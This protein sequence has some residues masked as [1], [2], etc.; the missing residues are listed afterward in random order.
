MPQASRILLLLFLLLAGN[1]LEM[2]VNFTKFGN[3]DWKNHLHYHAS[4]HQ[5]LMIPFFFFNGHLWRI[6]RWAIENVKWGGGGGLFC[7]SLSPLTFLVSSSVRRSLNWNCGDWLDG[8]APLAFYLGRL[9]PAKSRFSIFRPKYA[10]LQPMIPIF[11]GVAWGE[12][13]SCMSNACSMEKV[14]LIRKKHL[15]SDFLKHDIC[16]RICRV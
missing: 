8:Y 15:C 4:L 12:S 3:L 7:A 16:S 2:F 10:L 5:D 11:N 6:S 1:S 13:Y 14:S 9:H